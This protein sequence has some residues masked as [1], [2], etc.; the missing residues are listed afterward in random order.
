[1][2]PAS[3]PTLWTLNHATSISSSSTQ[4]HLEDVPVSQLLS[5]C[6]HA[7][8]HEGQVFMILPP[9]DVEDAVLLRE[10]GGH[11]VIYIR[12]LQGQA[13]CWIPDAQVAL[14]EWPPANCKGRQRCTW[15]RRHGSSIH[16][17]A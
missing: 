6:A 16:Q 5:T 11:V 4:A 13:A 2:R 3:K 17:I 9:D 12:Q 1:M 14:Q 7:V 8:H 15:Q 10:A